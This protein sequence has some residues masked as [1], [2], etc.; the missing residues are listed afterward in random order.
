MNIED[1]C[2]IHGCLGC[3]DTTSRS[4]VI[5]LQI[6]RFCDEYPR[7]VYPEVYPVED[8][9]KIVNPPGLPEFV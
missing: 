7:E 5:D 1:R 9:S 2:G 6:I 8:K 3:A 4:S